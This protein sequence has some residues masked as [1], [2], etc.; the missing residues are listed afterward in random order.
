MFLFQAL[1]KR[2]ALTYSVFFR[3]ETKAEI[4]DKNAGLEFRYRQGILRKWLFVE[5]V[6]SASWPREFKSEDREFN[7]GFGLFLEAYFGPTP[8]NELR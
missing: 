4:R 2:R 6:T 1:S 3:G 5:A 7:P 8:E